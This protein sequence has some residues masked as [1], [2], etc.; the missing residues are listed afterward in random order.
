MS[1]ALAVERHQSVR[2]VAERYLRR[3]RPLSALVAVL[4]VSMFV[5]AYVASSLLPAVVVAG[6]LLILLRAPVFQ[7]SGTIRL[8]TDDSPE[9]IA[10]SFAG[11]RP[12][13]LALQWGIA[14]EVS[15]DDGTATYRVSYL[16]GLRTAEVTVRCRTETTPGDGSRIELETAANGEPWATYTATVSDEADGTLVDVE[17]TSSRRFG[18]RRLPQRFVAERYRDE[19][20]AAQGYAVVDR[21]DQFGL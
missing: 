7:S 10:D 9:T 21:E 3:E 1:S 15:T 6:A 13:V 20:L 16:L 18:L 17:Y 2:P 8:R 14:D 12:P 11:P 19:A 5:G 4:A